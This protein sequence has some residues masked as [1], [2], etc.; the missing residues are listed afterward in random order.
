MAVKIIIGGDLV[1]T[2]SNCEYFK[3]GNIDELLGKEL[4]EKLQE[5]DFT[6]FNLEVPLSDKGIP[7][8]KC[9]PNLIASTETIKG[10]Q[11]INPH[12]FT[13]AN[14]HILDQGEQGLYSTL[15]IL[16]KAGIAY[17]GVG[18]NITQAAKPYIYEKEGI[19]IGI[20][21]CTE[22][23]FSIATEK[24]AGANPFDP[25][26]SVEHVSE[27]KKQCDYLIVL[28]HGGKEHYRYP[29]P[30]LQKLCRK[31][32]EYGANLIICQ[33]SHCIGCKEEWKSGTIIYG[34]GN[35]LFDYSES[36]FWKTGLLV[37]LEI[38]K[39]GNRIS[40]FPLVK[41]K[42]K[43]RM[44][45]EQKS[46]EILGDFE[47]RSKEIQKPETVQENYKKYA[48]SQRNMVLKRFD[49]ISTL[50]L[51][52]IINKLSNER[53]LTWYMSK[54]LLRNKQYGIWN[55]VECEAWRE[56]LIEAI[57]D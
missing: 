24:R 5:A 11:M 37:C 49:I 10:L 8:R 12:F 29:S 55:T 46:R 41:E 43:V 34:Q 28:Y 42:N 22:H 3:T 13:L 26:E 6:I 44:A 19:R 17:S 31:L 54:V 4:I 33:H 39:T 53:L 32:I 20:Y 38:E 47:N 56:L 35:F 30:G 18:K 45:A 15:D 16:D 57:R 52:K 21:C 48:Q 14:N 7:I 23:E 51:F 40:Y 50:L 2:K 25:L 36:E 27:L 9:G 1:P